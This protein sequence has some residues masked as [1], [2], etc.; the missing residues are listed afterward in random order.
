[1]PVDAL[2]EKYQKFCSDYQTYSIGALKAVYSK[3]RS[4]KLGVSYLDKE[5]TDISNYCYMLFFNAFFD[6]YLPYHSSEITFATLQQSINTDASLGSIS[7][8]LKKEPIF[9]DE[10]LRTLFLIKLLE[11]YPF[12]ANSV[13]KLLNEIVASKLSEQVIKAAKDVLRQTNTL[14][15]RTTA[16]A[17]AL[18]T[19]S[20]K[21]VKSETL[22]GK[23][24]YVNFFKT[25]CYDCLAEMELMRELYAKNSRFFE[26]VSICIDNDERT[27]QAFS[28]NYEYPW[29]VLYAGYEQDFILQWQAK[30]IPYYILIDKEYK[31]ISCPALAPTEDVHHIMEKTSWEEQRKEWRQQGNEN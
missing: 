6:E 14:L 30:I 15:P 20:G 29:T 9:F 21:T 18:P 16:P 27:F 23:F 8:I 22:K 4:L 26:F 17:F 28:K 2:P 3:K 19:A 12:R 31:I 5:K 7:D 11:Q 10:E 13:T 24:L 25:N 1:M